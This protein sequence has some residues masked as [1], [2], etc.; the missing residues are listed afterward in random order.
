MKAAPEPGISG[1][2]NARNGIGWLWKQES[3][4][5]WPTNGANKSYAGRW[6]VAGRVARKRSV[7]HIS[8]WEEGIACEAESNLHR[9]CCKDTCV[10]PH[11]SMPPLLVVCSMSLRSDFLE[12]GQTS[13]RGIPRFTPSVRLPM[14][15]QSPIVICSA[16]M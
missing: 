9:C 10:V 8:R 11:H 15:S 2:G 1:A 6:T 12:L 3:W 14:A 16:K 4:L 13:T 7:Q 5:E